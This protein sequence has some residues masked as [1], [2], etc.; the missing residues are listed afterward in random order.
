MVQK[1]SA[2][3]ARLN[4]IV[5]LDLKRKLIKTAVSQGKKVSALVRESIEEKLARVERKHFEEKMREAYLDM[6]EENL[7]TVEEF[8][9]VDAENL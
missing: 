6:G 5:P 4:L 1:I 3:D 8:K 2:K 9:Y 7:D